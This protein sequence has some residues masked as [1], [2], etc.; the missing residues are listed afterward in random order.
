MLLGLLVL[1]A[2][3]FQAWDRGPIRFENV[4]KI[5]AG[6]A[7]D[8]VVALIGCDPGVHATGPIYVK[9]PRPDGSLTFFEVTIDEQHFNVVRK[10]DEQ[11]ELWTWF[12]DRG[13]IVVTFD[14]AM[15]VAHVE[16][17]RARRSMPSAWQQFLER[18][19]GFDS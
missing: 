11:G 13:C 10:S 8:E 7:T 16:S 6:M 17:V 18:N 2:V 15:R 9:G 4:E 19:F 5:R 1:G 12:G 14:R 3:T